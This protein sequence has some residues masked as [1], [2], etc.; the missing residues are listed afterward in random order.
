MPL[1][2]RI[3]PEGKLFINGEAVAKNAGNRPIDLVILTD[4]PISR[5]QEHADKVSAE[6]KI[7]A[8]QAREHLND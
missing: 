7:E 5:T 3:K 2:I 6:L 1:K 8:H 4:K